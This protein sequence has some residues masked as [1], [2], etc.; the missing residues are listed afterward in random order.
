MDRMDG[1]WGFL[2]WIKGMEGM[3]WI[4]DLRGMPGCVGMP[5]AGG[6]GAGLRRRPV[7]MMAAGANWNRA[8]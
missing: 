7:N 1:I 2:A 3:G 6:W 5:V 8:V 4:L